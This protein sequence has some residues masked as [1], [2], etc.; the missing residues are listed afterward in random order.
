[1]G[2]DASRGNPD[3]VADGVTFEGS[4]GVPQSSRRRPNLYAGLVVRQ[5]PF[6]ELTVVVEE[7]TVL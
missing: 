4:T 2:D 5:R 7:G 3:V 6:D 1:M